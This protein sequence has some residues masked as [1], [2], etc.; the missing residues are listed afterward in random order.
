[1]S[2]LPKV[3]I[4]TDGGCIRNP[5]PGGYGVVLLHKNHR[6]ELSAGFRRTTNNRME[7]KAAIAGLQ[8]LTTRCRVTIHTDSRYLC[9][10]MTKKWVYG[11]KS[12]GW[13]KSDKT[14]ALNVDLWERLV[15]LCERHEMKFVWVKGHAGNVENERCDRLADAAAQQKELAIDIGYEREPASSQKGI[16]E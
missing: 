13:I 8:A 5:G 7:L 10:A 14:K 2:Q 1:M 6:K 4:Y 9:D 16:W 12:R 15:R 11:W 3:R